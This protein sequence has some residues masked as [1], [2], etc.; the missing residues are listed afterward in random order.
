MIPAYVPP[1]RRLQDHRHGRHRV[2]DADDD[3]GHGLVDDRPAAS[4]LVRSPR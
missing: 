4:W 1:A 2:A 3:E